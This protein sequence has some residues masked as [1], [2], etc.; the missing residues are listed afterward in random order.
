MVAFISM[1]YGWSNYDHFIRYR[2]VSIL[3]TA[4]VGVLFLISK[5]RLVLIPILGGGSNPPD[6][7]KYINMAY[8]FV[9]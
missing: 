2:F 8:G 9:S 6:F 1:V 4:G 5:C 3:I 7:Q